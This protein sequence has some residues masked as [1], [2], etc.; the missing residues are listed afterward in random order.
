MEVHGLYLTVGTA[1]SDRFFLIPSAA[2]S[3]SDRTVALLLPYKSTA[4]NTATV[5]ILSELYSVGFYTVSLNK[6]P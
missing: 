5:I 3:R 4:I 1:Y 6:L 2:P